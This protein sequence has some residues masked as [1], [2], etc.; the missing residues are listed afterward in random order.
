M[1]V[2]SNEFTQVR[3][4]VDISPAPFAPHHFP[5]LYREQSYPEREAY[6]KVI[7]LPLSTTEGRI[8]PILLNEP[9][10]LLP[11]QQTKPGFPNTFSSYHHLPSHRRV[12]PIGLEGGKCTRRS[13]KGR[14]HGFTSAIRS[15]SKRRLRREDGEIRRGSFEKGLERSEEWA[16]GERK[17]REYPRM[18]HRDRR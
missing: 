5:L 7:R 14:K 4:Q 2:L 13:S 9:P 16:E 12:F 1:I 11:W 8:D 17:E 3:P 10:R 6:F 18:E 15:A